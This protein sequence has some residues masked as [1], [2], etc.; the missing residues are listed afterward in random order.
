MSSITLQGK[1]CHTIGTLPAVGTK[2]PDFTLTKTDLSD[3]H[4]ADFAG[5]T[6]ILNIFPSIDTPTCAIAAKKFNEKA[7]QL[8]NTVVLCVSADLPFAQKRFCAAEGLNQIIPASIFRHPEFG[9]S[10][11]VKVIDG[12]ITGLLSRAVVIINEKGQVIYTQ[13][14]AEISAE[15]DYAAVF[16]SLSLA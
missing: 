11:G 4:L 3:I 9:T 15:P 6:I 1:P 8:A 13:Q 2:A 16:H 14:V 10:Y 12:P 7:N 5:K